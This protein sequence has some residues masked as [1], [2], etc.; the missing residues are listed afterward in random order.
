MAARAYRS[1]SERL[2]DEAFRNQ[3]L[4]DEALGVG[5]FGIARHGTA[6][7]ELAELMASA[8]PTAGLVRR[9]RTPDLN[10]AD[11]RAFELATSTAEAQI[12]EALHGVVGQDMARLLRDNTRFGTRTAETL[13]AVSNGIYRGPNVQFGEKI[14]RELEAISTLVTDAALG[15]HRA[16]GR[17]GR[18]PSAVL[19]ARQW[20]GIADS[21]S[22]L[23][24]P[25]GTLV[26]ELSIG[27]LQERRE[28][29]WLRK[30]RSDREF[31]KVTSEQVADLTVEDERFAKRLTALVRKIARHLWS[32]T[33]ART[34]RL[35]LYDVFG[36]LMG[37]IAL[38]T[39]VEKLIPDRPGDEGQRQVA[40][41]GQWL[42]RMID[43]LT[44]WVDDQGN[45]HVAAMPR[46]ETRSA[47]SVRTEAGITSKMRARLPPG[48][49]VAI[50]SVRPLWRSIIYRDPLTGDLRQGWIAA[51]LLREW[52]TASEGRSRRD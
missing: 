1:S 13:A 15:G 14:A 47:A 42:Y 4:I 43:Q 45:S 30:A 31:W 51:R 34:K 49:V 21:I 24:K 37:L 11:R 2:L 3:R 28:R 5:R 44:E 12:R 8:D 50:Q 36:L 48:T 16:F 35:D 27:D 29:A 26:G 38:G 20:L 52:D 10:A 41:A 25:L 40:E 23:A 18:V 6:T 19:E 17:S 33:R 9:L 22:E 46:A 7:A 32:N 39:V